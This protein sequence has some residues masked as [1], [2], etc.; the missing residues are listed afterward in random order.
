LKKSVGGKQYVD[1]VKWS[2]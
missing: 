2:K 1:M